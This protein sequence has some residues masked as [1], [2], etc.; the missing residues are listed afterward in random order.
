MP[1]M[2]QSETHFTVNVDNSKCPIEELSTLTKM[3]SYYIGICAKNQLLHLHHNYINSKSV[4]FYI[5]TD[6]SIE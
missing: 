4:S 3:C 6:Y 2:Y 1:N 5:I